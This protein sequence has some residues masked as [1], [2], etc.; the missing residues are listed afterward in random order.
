METIYALCALIGGTLLACQI[1]LGLLGIGGDHDVGGHDGDFHG[2]A[3]DGHHDV[4]HENE[5]HWFVGVFT[6][7]TL[8]A[9]LTLFGL[10]GLAGSAREWEQ[11]LPLAL[12]VACGAGG[13][14]LV[15]SLMRAM[16]K[17]KAEGTVRIERAVGKD[18]TVYLTVPGQKA[19][20]GKVTLNLQNRTVE[21]QAITAQEALPTGAKVVVVSVVAADTVEVAP[22]TDSRRISHV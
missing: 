22:A 18:G 10:G 19:G 8:V 15:A 16:H 12:A 14:F 13:L 1:V 11:P 9:A 17:L 5:T 20:V 21:Y 6:F 4:Q 3:H 7:R 2:D